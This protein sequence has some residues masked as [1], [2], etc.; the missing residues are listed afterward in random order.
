MQL[1]KVF[2]QGRPMEICDL[3]MQLQQPRPLVSL[4]KVVLCQLE[5][6]SRGLLLEGVECLL[7]QEAEAAASPLMADTWLGV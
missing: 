2:Q 7:T 3:V 4:N 5:L 6:L 1:K